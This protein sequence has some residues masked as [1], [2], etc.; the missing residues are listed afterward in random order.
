MDSSFTT[1]RISSSSDL[2]NE[3]NSDQND[4]LTISNQINQYKDS[5]YNQPIYQLPSD[6]DSSIYI[7]QNNLFIWSLLPLEYNIE[8]K[9]LIQ[10]TTC[11]YKKIESIKGFQVSNLARHYKTKHIHIAY[12]K[13]NEKERQKKTILLNS[14]KTTK[15][16]FFNIISPESRK[17]IRNNTITEFD[18]NEAYTKILTFIIENN[19]SF[20]ILN[21]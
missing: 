4:N 2:D 18:D 12:N 6:K 16:D 17:R 11:L 9:I 3:S 1:Q 14:T 15:S 19:L 13:G 20:N 7:F 10:C 5:K 8:W 21:S